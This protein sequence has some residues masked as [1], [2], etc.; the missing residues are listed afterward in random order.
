M[1]KDKILYACDRLDDI[2]KATELEAGLLA[3][4][5]EINKAT[6][7]I[8]NEV[9]ATSTTGIFAMIDN[10]SNVIKY[11]YGDALDILMAMDEL[12]E[13]VNAPQA[14]ER[15]EVLADFFHSIWSD[16]MKYQF[17]ECK[18]LDEQW[19]MPAWAVERWKR[20]MN[21][22]YSELPEEEKKSDRA[23]AIRLISV[24]VKAPALAVAR[25]P[26]CNGTGHVDNGF[27]TQTSGQWASSSSTPEMC[28]SCNGR[29]Y[30]TLPEAPE[31]EDKCTD[32][33]LRDIILESSEQELREVLSETGENFDSIAAE[34]K[35]VAQRALADAQES[36]GRIEVDTK[37]DILPEWFPQA[38]DD[39]LFE[40]SPDKPTHWSSVEIMDLVHL[41]QTHAWGLRERRKLPDGGIPE[42]VI[43]QCI[44]IANYA[45]M[46]ADNIKNAK[47]E[48]PAED[49]CGNG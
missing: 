24:E 21:T 39:V 2:G 30:V 37:Y 14:V 9:N 40:K 28:R 12:K 46:I 20:Q 22:P 48:A 47:P 8:R 3:Y 31:T 4:R 33:A 19:L 18:E 38:M 1:N 49:T 11:R 16:W 13:K 29:G 10:I 5:Q 17:R 35:A 45:M 32:R 23:L 25:C 41:L 34:G 43:R 6:D 26:V 42:A 44:H 7:A 36:D 15:I 27:Y